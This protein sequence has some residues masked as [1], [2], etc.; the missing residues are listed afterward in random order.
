MRIVLIGQAA[1]GADVLRALVQA[2][3]EVVAAYTIPD[4]PGRQEPVA[5]VAQA[6]GVPCHQPPRLRSR[7]V[8]E[9]VE[10]LQADLGVM[11]YVTE[12]VPLRLL[13]AP[14][15]GTIQYHPSLLPRHR[16][17]SAM[18]WAIIQGE[19]KTGLTIFWPDAGIDTGP[20]LLQ[21]EVEIEPDDTLGSLYF[22][23]LYPMG[24]EAILEAVRLVR[25]GRAPRIPQ[26][27]SQA[28]YEPVC[29]EEHAIIDWER[30]LPELYN[31]IRGTNPQPGATTWFRGSKLK[32]FECSR[33]SEPREAPPG[34]IVEVTEQGVLIAAKGGGLL[35]HRVQV[36][37]SPKVSAHQFALE[38]GIQPGE[39]FSAPV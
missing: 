4:A 33:S 32:L 21:R 1:F 22:N 18:H 17:A 36:P 24:I 30:P 13:Q 19:T 35:V 39:R 15:L 37:G 20:I 29:T 26:D 9:Q 8:I 11:A 6:L 27:E 28:T 5:A 23:K 14:A 38:T 16:G 25:E 2:G 31:L 7:H 12:I 34:T 3:E 10:S